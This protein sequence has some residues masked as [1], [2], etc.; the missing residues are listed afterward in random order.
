MKILPAIFYGLAVLAVP[1]T[2]EV[3]LT[4]ADF[5]VDWPN[6]IGKEVVIHDGEIGLA[7]NESAVLGT[8]AGQVILHGPWPN[9][10]DLR[11][12]LKNC[13]GLDL[14]PACQRSVV[15]TAVHNSG[16]P[17]LEGVRLGK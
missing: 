1:A 13:S 14:G 8:S 12:I 16:M 17:T 11:Y 4:V 15:G 10:E 7:H 5:I 9:R 3:R 2:A 6:Y